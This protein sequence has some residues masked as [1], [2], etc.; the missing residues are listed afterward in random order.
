MQMTPSRRL[1]IFIPATS[2]SGR[3][4]LTGCPLN[5]LSL[6]LRFLITANHGAAVP[7]FGQASTYLSPQ[8]KLLWQIS[9]MNV[10]MFDA[11]LAGSTPFG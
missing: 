2:T 11:L 3:A 7:L 9:F 4:T 5:V 6:G 8:P 1:F 10:Y